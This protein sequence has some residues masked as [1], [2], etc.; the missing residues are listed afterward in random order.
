MNKKIKI[1][2]LSAVAILL[3]GIG[4]VIYLFQ[5]KEYEV[6]DEE[7]D[8]IIQDSY[9][10]TLPDGSK[11]IVEDEQQ[12]GNEKFTTAP[13][14]VSEKPEK[15]QL[16][17]SSAS[18][19]STKNT[20]IPSSTDPAGSK[21]PDTQQAM[22]VHVPN[23]P[24]STEG[25]PT[26]KTEST[27]LDPANSGKRESVASIKSKYTPTIRNLQ[28]QV[29]EKIHSL[30]GRAKNEYATKKV[31][32]ESID[33]GYF[34]TKYMAAAESLEAQTDAVFYG[35]I[36]SLEKDLQSNGHDR[37][38]AQSVKDEYA[39]QKKARQDSVLSNMLR[40]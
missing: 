6:A 18:M 23:T 31:N 25:I 33:Y 14:S 29:D 20:E 9:D 34:Y 17:G 11:L 26:K 24:T 21:Q 28:T 32:G 15:Q 1:F 36:S 2:L 3:I 8:E 16:N 19:E 10:I 13:A 22:T 30:I 7:V 5:F 40:N 38:Y 12:S 39:A 37:S 27:I 35:V 4:Y